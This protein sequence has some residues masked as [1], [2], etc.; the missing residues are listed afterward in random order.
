MKAKVSATFGMFLVV[1]L[2]VTGSAQIPGF[3]QTDE[4][5]APY[6]VDAISFASVN[7]TLSRLDV[8]TQVP[9]E[10]L[11]FLR[12][13]GKYRA[14]YDMSV[15]IL[16]EA[17]KP[18][19]E[20]TWTE[21]VETSAFDETASSQAYSLTQ[22]SFEVP[23]GTYSIITT[24]RDNETKNSR[25]LSRNIT[26]TDYNASAFTL[27]DIMLVARLSKKD[28][29][30][31]VVPLVS[32][33]VGQIQEAFHIFFEVY[34]NLKVDTVNFLVDIL[35]ERKEKKLESQETA[36]LIPGRNQVF[37]RI[38]H[39]SLP[40]G[41]YTLYVRAFPKGD[42]AATSLASTSRTFTLRW[43]GLPTSLKDLDEA[44]SQVQ[45]IAKGD[46]LSYIKEGDTPEERQKRLLEF[47]KRRDPNPNTPRNERMEEYYARVEYANK[48]FSHY[49]SGWR[50]DMGMV[51][52]VLGPPSNVDRHPFD[53]DSKPYEVWSYYEWN[54]QFVFVDQTGFGD[55]RMITPI[56]E[57]WQH[58]KN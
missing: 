40:I 44:I 30:R 24:L 47:W 8:F 2:H 4:E 46:E 31:I 52:I 23:P 26:V 17:G 5:A 12:R 22:R 33:N 48:H 45:Y 16:D 58:A 49:T 43:R 10:Q 32:R 13:D 37:L 50:T 21:E 14:S 35:N 7:S 20:K 25:R 38:D 18:V 1:A 34:N 19:A 53:M 15:N 11:S 55:Y 3:R 57:L 42:S 36:A 28:G 6:A 27:S 54:Q 9:Y 29:K 56:S 39:T 51:Y 41:E